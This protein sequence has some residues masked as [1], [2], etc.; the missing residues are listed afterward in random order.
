M[1][2]RPLPRALALS[3]IVLLALG[4]RLLGF[5]EVFVGDDVVFRLG[6]PCYHLRL[7]LYAW[8]HFPAFLSFD[9]YLNFPD[10][11][12]VPW[13]PLYDLWVAGSARL[14]GDS[15]RAL[16][17]WAA[18]WPPLLGALTALPVYAV[19]R[20][21]GGTGLGLA[22][23][24]IFALLP[25][26][27]ATSRVGYA[28]HHAAQVLL[29]AALL[30]LQVR[31]H[32]A[33]SR[34]GALAVAAGLGA[35]RAALLG[36]WLGSFAYLAVAELA[37][38]GVAT[39][40]ARGRVLRIEAASLPLTA[41]LVAPL[42]VPSPASPGGPFSPFELSWLHVTACLA[43]ALWALA[44]ERA[45]LRAAGAGRRLLRAGFLGAPAAA[46]L[47]ALPGVASGVLGAAGFVGGDLWASV[48]PEQQPLFQAVGGRRF[49]IV[50]F[51]HLGWVLPLAPLVLA[52]GA[53]GSRERAPLALAAC[54]AVPLT[55][56]AVRQSRFATDAAPTASLA[57][58]VALGWLSGALAARL[59]LRGL[60]AALPVCA[61]GAAALWPT[62]SLE[63]L[64]Q[65]R[66][67][68]AGLRATPGDAALASAAGSLHRFAETVRAVTPE[69]AG[70]LDPSRTPEYGILGD[71]SLGHAL[72]YV[73]RR[74][75][76]SDNLGVHIGERNLMA[77]LRVLLGP[78][79]EGALAELERMRVR[80]LV[81]SWQ[82]AYPPG[83][84]LYQLHELDGAATAHRG[85]LA[86][87]R[88]VAEG[89]RGE[90]PLAAA[91]AA[92]RPR[93]DV[94][95][96]KLFEVVAGAVLEVALPPGRTARVSLP[97]SVAGGRR[98]FY[99]T[100][101]EADADGFARIR[102]PYATGAGGLVRSDGPYRVEAGGTTTC[103]EVSEADVREGRT[104]RVAPG[105]GCPGAAG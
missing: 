48:N 29:A 78:S 53:W 37:A 75:T 58:A 101:A 54:W 71:P 47:L 89:P 72:H 88:L 103:V 42:A 104:V 85:A 57:F 2:N 19:G 6:D 40:L 65:W 35:L 55:G 95:P 1:P 73:A 97:L 96:Y 68:L 45:A 7:A 10:G 64:P 21:A 44:C 15:P 8:T 31:A 69:T 76:P 22:A 9:R 50:L 36:V 13:P 14:F 91:L 3:G 39:A 84:L 81:T 79:L 70:F 77:T 30:A 27:T 67:T 62:V 52:L 33:T 93:A 32:A 38:V 20:A 100:R 5:P 105:V 43:A 34:R 49:A 90:L 80:Y 94:V 92:P 17:L 63:H 86:R 102:V 18:L 51:G 59:H 24:A 82:P 99:R 12:Y 60:A 61:L 16:E 83:S 56:L 4:L 25:A 66:A 28:D 74:P 11:A 87:F 26:S 98:T 41:L 23:A 46:A